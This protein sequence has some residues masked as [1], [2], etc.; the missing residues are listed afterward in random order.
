MRVLHVD[1]QRLCLVQHEMQPTLWY[2]SA[3]FSPD[4]Q[5]GV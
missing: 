3:Y 2:P 5:I 4:T 1:N